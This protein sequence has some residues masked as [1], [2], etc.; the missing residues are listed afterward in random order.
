[1]IFCKQVALGLG[2]AYAASAFPRVGAI[3]FP[4]AA[5]EAG[6]E[7]TPLDTTARK[8]ADKAGT[9]KGAASNGDGPAKGGK[10]P[11]SSSKAHKDPTTPFFVA[12]ASCA[13]D[14]ISANYSP[15]SSFLT[16]AIQ[17][18]DA[19]SL[20]QQWDLLQ[21]GTFI[22][23][24]SVGASAGST[25]GWCLGVVPQGDGLMG[26]FERMVFRGGVGMIDFAGSTPFM[27]PF[28]TSGDGYE[29]NDMCSSGSKLGLVHC[30]DPA[31][32]WYPTDGQLLSALCWSLGFTSLLTVNEDCNELS[33]S[34]TT[35]TD[36]ATASIT[37]AETFMVVDKEFVESIPPP[38]PT[39]PAPTPTETYTYVPTTPPPTDASD[40]P[41]SA[42][43]PTPTTVVQQCGES[44]TNKKVALSADLTCPDPGLPP[45]TY[46]CA[47][48]LD[49]PEAEID[50]NDNTLSQ[51]ASN[52]PYWRGICLW[53]GATTRNCN[54]NNFWYGISVLN[55]AEV[56]KSVLSNNYGGID[57]VFDVEDSKLTI[58]DT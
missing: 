14:C 29:D 19:K 58:T 1:M 16:N 31:S 11:P 21:H 4:H 54:V 20:H 41:S 12:S 18:C 53:N 26:M 52:H 51:E 42:P 49:G 23:V 5:A 50:C 8:L 57:A 28:I 43:T 17:P 9:G 13:G 34:M 37:R 25:D 15:D 44:F 46:P 2:V 47:I 10:N 56:V 7:E 3:A 48:K 24:K 55:N 45:G 27:L 30:G 39:T 36:G 6:D 32:H 38:A 40:Q 22:M 33:L 35:A